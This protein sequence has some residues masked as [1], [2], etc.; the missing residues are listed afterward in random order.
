M[1]SF[2]YGFT[3]GRYGGFAFE[4][5]C[6]TYL[7]LFEDSSQLLYY[8][9]IFAYNF[10][11]HVVVQ[12]E[13]TGESPRSGVD[14][15][16]AKVPLLSKGSTSDYSPAKLL[17][18]GVG[19][20]IPQ[21]QGIR[22]SKNLMPQRRLANAHQSSVQTYESASNHFK[23]EPWFWFP[24]PAASWDGSDHLGRFVSPKDEFPWKIRASILSSVR[25]HQGALRSLAACQD[26]NTVFTAGIGPGFK[27]TVQKWDLTRIN[28][29]SG[30]YGHEE[31][32]YSVIMFKGPPIFPV[33][34]INMLVSNK[35]SD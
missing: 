5:W 18:N 17:L 12:W 22:S 31:V 13:Y 15:V 28:C 30:Y 35:F 19:W 10:S 26:E 27:G 1:S 3:I 14:N 11:E 2:F 21:S 24:S 34:C 16:I 32:G 7:F 25:V 9:N 33:L 29:V 6:V 20:S 4:E 8:A 23:T